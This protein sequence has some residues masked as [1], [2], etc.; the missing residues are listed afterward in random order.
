MTIGRLAGP[1]VF[2]KVYDKT[3]NISLVALAMV[4]SGVIFA[5]DSLAAR[6]TLLCLTGLA[7]GK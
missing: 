1:T 7:W 3:R 5:V 6:A 4:F 2:K